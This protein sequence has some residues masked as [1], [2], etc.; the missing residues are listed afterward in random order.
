M[1][2]GRQWAHIY[3]Q[4]RSRFL[5]VCFFLA[6][7]GV[8]K[9]RLIGERTRHV[10]NTVPFFPFLQ[11]DDVVDKEDVVIKLQERKGRRDACWRHM[12]WATENHCSSPTE[13]KRKKDTRWAAFS[14]CHDMSLPLIDPPSFSTKLVIISDMLT[15]SVLCQNITN[16]LLKRQRIE[17]TNRHNRNR[18]RI[19]KL[20]RR[21]KS[22]RFCCFSVGGGR[23]ITYISC[24]LVP[25][26]LDIRERRENTGPV[27]RKREICCAG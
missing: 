14:C 17:A 4:H 3:W 7:D 15:V 9:W 18:A 24:F 25:Q 22:A 13:V 5:L 16:L 19:K 8:N 21:K 1:L 11:F 26:V 27:E 23:R 20:Q 10:D 6:I 12:S 2:E